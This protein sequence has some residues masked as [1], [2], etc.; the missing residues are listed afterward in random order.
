MRAGL[1]DRGR[2][3]G[4]HLGAVYEHPDVVARPRWRVPRKPEVARGRVQSTAPTETRQTPAMMRG[5]ATLDRPADEVIE[6]VEGATAPIHRLHH[7]LG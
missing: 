7:P 6:E 4:Q 5:H 2:Y 1:G 3:P